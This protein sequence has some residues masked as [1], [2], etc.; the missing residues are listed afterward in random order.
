[1][2]GAVDTR[3]PIIVPNIYQLEPPA[4]TRFMSG[5]LQDLDK[6]GLLSRILHLGAGYPSGSVSQPEEDERRWKAWL[7][8]EAERKGVKVR[9]LLRIY[10]SY[11]ATDGV[12]EF[13]ANFATVYGGDFGGVMSPGFLVP[14]TGST[15]G[16]DLLLK[17]VAQTHE[18]IAIITD[19]PTYAG[20]ISLVKE[21]P[22]VTIFSVDM[23]EEGPIPEKFAEAID[24]ARKAGRFVPFYYA[25][26]DGHNPGGLSMS[27][28]RRNAIY[29]ICR[30]KE[31]MI[32]EDAP[33]TYITYED[34][35]SRAKP[36]FV[37]DPDGRVIHVFTGS[38]IWEPGKRIG[39]LHV[40]AQW[41]TQDGKRVFA[42]RDMILKAAGTQGL[43]QNPESF[44]YFNAMLH[45]KNPDGTFSLGSL[46]PEAERKNKVYGE[47]R[48]IFLAGLNH[49]FEGVRDRVSWTNSKAGFF[50][51]I[52][53]DNVPFVTDMDFMKSL[54]YEDF[55]TTIPLKDFFPDDAILRDA[56]VVNNQLRLSFSYTRAIKSRERKKEI[57]MAIERF[58]QA[59]LRRLQARTMPPGS[60]PSVPKD[61]IVGSSSETGQV[62]AARA[63]PPSLDG[64]LWSPLQRAIR[65][66]RDTGSAQCDQMASLLES[67][68]FDLSLTDSDTIITMIQSGANEDEIIGFV[69]SITGQQRAVS[70]LDEVGDPVADSASQA[71][72][73]GVLVATQGL[74]ATVAG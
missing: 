13:R 18:P 42:M 44:A 45:R 9:D 47:N 6:Q 40:P 60:I 35:A 68:N 29:K 2:S 14:T 33:Y 16:L 64:L 19:S 24:A 72:T 32:A 10:R 48:S 73:S 54:I 30:E 27:Q 39:Y 63:E 46:W 56:R 3:I 8:F 52:K 21:Y 67:S 43:F 70:T 11:G 22:N 5:M 74:V 55:V 65:F 51:V 31:I 25:I 34:E 59:I 12:E 20:F 69:N 71:V 4:I 57:Q 50:V 61:L 37:N 28:E 53:F 66:L 1:M 58:C 23:D 38:K 17:V 36:F 62:T 7:K 41:Q 15:G 26:P 49:Y